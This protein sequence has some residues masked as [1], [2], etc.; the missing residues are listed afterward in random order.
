[1]PVVVRDSTRARLAA[2]LGQFHLIRIFQ[3]PQAQRRRSELQT[4]HCLGGGNLYWDQYGNWDG[5]GNVIQAET[6]NNT[7]TLTLDFTPTLSTAVVLQSAHFDRWAGGGGTMSITWS[8]T[9]PSSGT[10]ASGVWTR[11]PGGRDLV[12]FNNST[13]VIGEKLTLS[14]TNTD[15]VASGSYFAIDNLTFDQVPEPS[16]A[17]LGVAGL[18]ALALRRRRNRR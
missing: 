4:S 3:H 5:R 7:Q 1:M 9:G 8:V 17:A 6:Y 15:G 16:V 12:N 14:L 10:L 11:G 13:G 18:G 2:T